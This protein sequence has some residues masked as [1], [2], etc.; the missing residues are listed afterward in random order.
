MRVFAG[1]ISTGPHSL[2]SA[3]N[4]SYNVI[5]RALLPARNA[6]TEYRPQE[7]G[8]FGL[9]NWRLHFGQVQRG[10]EVMGDERIMAFDTRD[11]LLKGVPCVSLTL[12]L[13]RLHP[14]GV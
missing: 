13:N 14:G 4:R 5:A 11:H 8:I 9:M 12:W 2:T 1:A 3:V 10:R 7:C 6:S